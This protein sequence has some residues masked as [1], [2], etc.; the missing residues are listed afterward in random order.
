MVALGGISMIDGTVQCHSYTVFWASMGASEHCIESKSDALGG[1]ADCIEVYSNVAP[2]G[3][4]AHRL[5]TCSYDLSQA[6]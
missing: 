3:Q 1:K 5:W 4:Y 6:I 2:T